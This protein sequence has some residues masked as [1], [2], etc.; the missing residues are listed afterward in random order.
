MR[1]SV[2]GMGDDEKRGSEQREER[3]EKRKK[4]LKVLKS[5]DLKSERETQVYET[6]DVRRGEDGVVGGL[7]AFHGQRCSKT[8]AR[9]R[10]WSGFQLDKEA[11]FGEGCGL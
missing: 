6:E 3:R 4:G 5:K 8:A 7:R 9:C 2:E 10:P 11:G 1:K